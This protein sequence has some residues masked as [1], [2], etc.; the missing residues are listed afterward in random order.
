MPEFV[1]CCIKYAKILDT[2]LAVGFLATRKLILKAQELELCDK[3]AKNN[4][5]K[6]IDS[7]CHYYHKHTESLSL[8]EGFGYEFY[9]YFCL[10]CL[11]NIKQVRYIN[12][13]FYKPLIF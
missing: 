13:C 5:Y 7:E 1:L 2:C 9:L 10:S 12:L 8:E 3:V 4:W 11:A 6:Y